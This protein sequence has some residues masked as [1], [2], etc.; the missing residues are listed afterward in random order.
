MVPGASQVP[1][2]QVLVGLTVLVELTVPVLKA[3]AQLVRA[4]ALLMMR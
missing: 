3:L 2:V 1:R 4:F